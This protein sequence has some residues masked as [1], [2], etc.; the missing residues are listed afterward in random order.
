MGPGM[1]PEAVV[2]EYR[3]FLRDA[4]ARLCPRDMGL[5]FDDI[6]QEA[7]LKL[8]SALRDEMEV[9]DLASYAYRI[10]A[11]TTI[12]AIRRARARREEQLRLEG[13]EDDEGR[14]PHAI[15]AASDRSPEREAE[16]RELV[17]KVEAALSR[18][19][20]NRLRAVRLYLEGMTTAEIA[21]LLGWTEPK[22][23]NLVY[24][25]LADLREQLTGL[26]VTAAGWQ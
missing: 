5:Q 9:R 25:G 23:R 18:L 24:R 19:A 8:L 11:T 22:A 13:E 3:A 17:A 2:E 21:N 20:E 15:P 26:G 10:A 7:S 1:S 14:G 12:D 4:V 16:R 6:V